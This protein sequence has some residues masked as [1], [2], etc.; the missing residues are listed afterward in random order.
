MQGPFSILK[1]RAGS[2]TLHAHLQGPRQGVVGGNEGFTLSGVPNCMT[3]WL[4][5]FQI[6]SNTG[7]LLQSHA[8]CISA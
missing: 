4:Q 7:F 1:S 2:Q 5:G 3:S 6:S 8:L